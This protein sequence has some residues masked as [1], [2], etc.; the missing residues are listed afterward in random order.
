M[1]AHIERLRKAAEHLATVEDDLFRSRRRLKFA[2]A[3]LRNIAQ[4][5]RSPLDREAI[6]TH[7]EDVARMLE[8]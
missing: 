1:S 8:S 3:R 6:A 7:A 5:A 2:A 4:L